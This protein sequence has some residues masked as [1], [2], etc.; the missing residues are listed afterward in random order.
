MSGYL[1]VAS[2]FSFSSSIIIII[3]QILEINFPFFCTNE[4]FPQSKCTSNKFQFEVKLGLKKI[5]VTAVV[6]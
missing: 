6:T 5:V 2:F 1:Q 3:F 4:K